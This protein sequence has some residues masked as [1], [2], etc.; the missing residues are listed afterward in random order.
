M[1]TGKGFKEP[2]AGVFQHICH[3]IKKLHLLN[4]SDAFIKEVI[5]G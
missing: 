4:K 5:D 1:A 2:V 3:I